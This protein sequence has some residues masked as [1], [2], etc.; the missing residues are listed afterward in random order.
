MGRRLKRLFWLTA[1]LSAALA[2][3]LVFL[4]RWL[5]GAGQWYFWLVAL[6]LWGGGMGWLGWFFT[7]RFLQPLLG[8]VEMSEAESETEPEQSRL[9]QLYPE[10]LPFMKELARRQVQKEENLRQRQEF[11]A[12]V[13]HELKTPL[14]SIFGY[15]EMIETGIAEDRDIKEFAGKIRA[16][17]GR[18]LDL[19]RDILK[20]SELDEPQSVDG[21]SLELLELLPIAQDTAGLLAFSAQRAGVDLRVSGCYAKVLATRELL[22]ELIYNLCDNAI[23]YNRRG[24]WVRMVVEETAKG[25]RLV[26]S[27]NGIGIPPEHQE[28]I[29]ERFYRADKSRSKASGGTG[30]GLAIVKHIVLQLSAGL[31]LK[32]REGEGTTIAILF[33]PAGAADDDVQSAPLAP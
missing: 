13:S 9:C 22:E 16:E 21:Q 20:L 2:A 18:L 24:G 7:R 8:A 33:K 30:L 3:A 4:C 29:F 15:A 23:R 12:N 32:S 11:S 25:V 10:L 17:A 19:I 31:E 26:V 5:F 27:D 28:R 6:V 14:T 1:G